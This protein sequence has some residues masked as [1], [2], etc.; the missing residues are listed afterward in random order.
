MRPAP[1]YQPPL[2][3]LQVVQSEERI[4]DGRKARRLISADD[5]GK[6][7]IGLHQV[8]VLSVR[9]RHEASVFW[10]VFL[11]Q[12]SLK[13]EAL[14]PRS[15]ISRQHAFMGVCRGHVLCAVERVRGVFCPPL[16]VASR[17]RLSRVFLSIATRPC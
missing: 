13:P 6:I 4:G 5:F 10:V 1:G 3:R 11:P 7:K 14:K 16:P 8:S 17:G 15:E 9:V 12:L 2:L